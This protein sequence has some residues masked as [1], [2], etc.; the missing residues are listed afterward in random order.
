MQLG[1]VHG[2]VQAECGY[3]VSWQVLNARGWVSQSRERVYIVG[4]RADL[5]VPP[6]DWAVLKA[7]SENA[8]SLNV[9]D[10]LEPPESAAV[11]RSP[12]SNS[13]A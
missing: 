3:D 11:V 12:A 5:Q 13:C 7:Q 9:A 2:C 1:S 6:M 8:C 10:V 4:F